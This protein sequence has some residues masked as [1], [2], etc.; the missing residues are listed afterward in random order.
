M[1]IIQFPYGY[2]LYSFQYTINQSL[3]NFGYESNLIILWHSIHICKG[4]K[5]VVETLTELLWIIVSY[6][7]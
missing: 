7:S 5:I 2:S 4:K 3:L 1:Q 6:K